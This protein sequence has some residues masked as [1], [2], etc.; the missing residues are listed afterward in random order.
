[1][2]N[3]LFA[4]LLLTSLWVFAQ[5]TSFPPR[6]DI[7]YDASVPRIDISIRQSS[8]DSLMLYVTSD[9]EFDV[10]FVFTG[11]GIVDSMSRVGFR[12]RGN[13]S[14]YAQ[15]KSYKVA[16]NSFTG[17]QRWQGVKKLNLNGEHNDPSMSRARLSWGILENIGLPAAR[18][19]HV[20]LY[21][22]GVYKG[23]YANTEHINDDYV[24]KR[25]DGKAGN[26]YKCLWPAT[27]S[28]RGSTGN[29][30]KHMDNG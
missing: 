1:M 20:R 19:N 15:K 28:Y 2:R 10:D 24:E 4:L 26:L 13:T 14:R 12:L 23:L 17:G 11:N 21:I 3:R 7:Y 22:N 8:L 27:L 30:Y 5:P 9:V 18:V 25:F 6:D 29:D 16:F